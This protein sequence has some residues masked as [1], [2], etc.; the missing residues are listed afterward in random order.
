MEPGRAVR[1]VKP[2]R[3]RPRGE[4]PSPGGVPSARRK[5]RSVIRDARILRHPLRAILSGVPLAGVSRHRGAGSL[6]SGDDETRAGGHAGHAATFTPSWRIAFPRWRPIGSQKGPV[7]HPL[8]EDL[9]PPAQSDSQRLSPRRGVLTL[10]GAGSLRSGDDGTRAGGHAG[11]AA[12]FTPSW[13]IAFPR[14][15]PIGSPVHLWGGEPLLF[16]KR[17]RG[18]S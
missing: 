6:R 13:R 15:R 11:H 16:T 12:T 8:L 10:R 1:P 7:S 17:S 3:S 2:Q 4:S 5:G 9:T 14:W 18:Q